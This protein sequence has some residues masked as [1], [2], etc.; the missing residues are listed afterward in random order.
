M[1]GETIR[2]LT[3]HASLTQRLLAE[4]VAQLVNLAEVITAALASGR[5]L[6]LMGNGGSAAD[7]QHFAAEL[8]GRFRGERP[9]W[10]AIA[11]TTDSSL[12]TALGNDYGF[13]AIFLRQIEALAVPGD[14]VL[15]ISTSGNS[16]NVLAGLTAAKSKG[17]VTVGLLGRDGGEIG[18]VVDHA[19]IVPSG[20]TPRIQEMHVLAIHIVCELVERALLARVPDR[21]RPLP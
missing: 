6:L 3:E 16:R 13:E 11:L 10:P 2:L 20:S 1:H 21:A 5:K 19:L 8:V 18:R 17:C 15:G 9:A 12:L 14:I 4:Q 7:A